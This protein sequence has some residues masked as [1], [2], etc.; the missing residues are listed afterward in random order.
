MQQPI[1]HFSKNAD[2]SKWYS[3]DDVVMGGKSAGYLSITEDGFGCFS[4]KI[5]KE[6]NGGFSSV[7]F[8]EHFNCS[9]QDNIILRAKGDGKKYQLRIKH[10]DEDRHG[11]I[12]NFQTSEEWEQYH[13][14]L[15]EMQPYFRG[16]KLPM[17]NFMATEFKEV[18]IF[19]LSEEAVSFNL[20]IDSLD[21]ETL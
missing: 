9:P 2:L 7:H 12:F 18:S 14:P 6:N 1:F 13:I 16:N 4:G 19:L 15:T 20:L 11:Y 10:K 8:R 21:L 17:E 3:V 5:S